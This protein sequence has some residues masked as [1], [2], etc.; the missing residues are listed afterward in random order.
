LADPE[1]GTEGKNSMSG[2]QGSLGERRSLG[3]RQGSRKRLNSIVTYTWLWPGWTRG[4]LGEWPGLGQAACFTLLVDLMLLVTVVWDEVLGSTAAW[5]GWSLAAVAWTIG[6][7]AGR[8][9]LKVLSESTD[10][11]AVAATSPQD[12]FPAALNEYLQGNWLV[13]EEKCRELVRRRRDD[14]EARL[15]LATLLRHTERLDEARQALVELEKFDGA[16]RW[17]M[18][19][20]CERQLLEEAEANVMADEAVSSEDGVSDDVMEETDDGSETTGMAGT[21]ERDGSEESAVSVSTAE[22]LPTRRA[23]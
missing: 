19:I 21:T 16:V 5:F 8:R 17:E 11:A 7:V 22:D 10:D 6:A 13:A 15:L 14:V 12:L 2:R 4:W 23:A 20:A 9:R 3:E 18:E 1:D